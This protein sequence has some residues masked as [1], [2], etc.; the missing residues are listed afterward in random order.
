[1]ARRELG[2]AS[3]AV[4]QAV[5]A[6]VTDTDQRLLVAC[7]GGADSLALAFA[8]HRVAS[9][10]GRAVGAVV[11][12]H[13][14]QPGSADVAVRVRDRLCDLGLDPVRV[15]TVHIDRAARGGPESAAR[16]AR[17]AALEAEAAAVS[18]R[19]PYSW[20]TPWMTRLRPCCWVWRVAQAPDR[21]LAWRPAPGTWSAPCWACVA[22]SPS[23]PATSSGSSPGPT[24]R[25]P[26]G[27]SPECASGHRCCPPSRPSWVLESRRPWPGPP[28]S[29]ATTRTCSI[30]WRL[31]RIP[32]PTPSIARR[33][34]SC[35]RPYVPGS[36]AAGCCGTGFGSRPRSTSA[37][38]PRWSPPGAGR[39]GS[40]CPGY[41]SSG[42][43]GS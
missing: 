19:P 43:P 30:S 21:W 17:Y 16:A 10:L 5:A 33:C 42:R 41:A 34:V 18:P 6:G 2:P 13:G 35:R 23:R 36:S 29:P 1:M 27:S 31:R 28:S 38:S 39:S 26:T 25:T 37:W 4:V 9:R 22:A 3:L 32:A 12:D 11:V 24:R 15:V 20:G 14:L 8:A 40:I 7:S